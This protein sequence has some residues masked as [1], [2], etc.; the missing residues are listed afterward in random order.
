MQIIGFYQTSKRFNFSDLLDHNRFMDRA[1]A[2]TMA[3]PSAVPQ[4]VAFN[5]AADIN[6]SLA[7][8]LEILQDASRPMKTRRLTTADKQ[9]RQKAAENALRLLFLLSESPGRQEPHRKAIARYD[10]MIPQLLAFVQMCAKTGR[11]NE[12]S[13]ALLVLKNVS[14]P[15][16]N[17]R[18]IAFIFKG[19]KI[20]GQLLANDPS[21]YM[22]A[23]ILANLTTG[24]GD[25]CQ[26]L[27]AHEDGFYFIEAVVYTLRVASMHQVDLT[28][29]Q[30]LIEGQSEMSIAD[31]MRFMAD[32]ENHFAKESGQLFL[33]I[34]SV[35]VYPET[36][37][38]CLIVLKNITRPNS[39]SLG[40]T[41]PAHLV[42]NSGVVRHLLRFITM[43]HP[44][45]MGHQNRD[46]SENSV[47]ESKSSDDYTPE[48]VAPAMTEETLETFSNDP[49]TWDATSPQDAAMFILMN[50]TLVKELHEVLRDMYVVPMLKDVADFRPLSINKETAFETEIREFQQLKARISLGWII[51][52]ALVRHQALG[53]SKKLIPNQNDMD[54]IVLS[55]AQ[56]RSFVQILSDALHGRVIHGA[57]GTS[58]AT[59]TVQC[60]LYSLRCLLTQYENQIKFA[61]LA[62]PKL[63]TLLMKVLAIEATRQDSSEEF[64]VGAV[65]HALYS[66]YLLSCHGFKVCSFV[67]AI[68]CQISDVVDILLILSYHC[69]ALVCLLAALVHVN[70][71]L[72]QSDW[73]NPCIL[74]Q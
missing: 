54:S 53:M 17:K 32:E 52:G 24:D 48:P 69:S 34:P 45:T 50:L 1:V 35:K 15:M 21:N 59:L 29:H 22:I 2:N 3:S 13:L 58:R 55:D 18:L 63:N 67:H 30:E 26:E 19:A 70:K 38:W 62:G 73:Q 28:F 39:A 9:N 33:P 7:G 51:G 11:S 6:E 49:K 64:G 27:A 36:A 66:L 43:S 4:Q 10:Q 8:C 20:L 12:L 25:L 47:L 16:E 31:R 44:T 41:K 57:P 65:E 60:M 74:Q 61:H 14:T 56:V 42:A 23:I 68:H 46:Q 5:R 71:H 40:N 72:Q 37:R